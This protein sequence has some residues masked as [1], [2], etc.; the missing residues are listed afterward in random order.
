MTEQIERPATKKKKLPD[1]VNGNRTNKKTNS[2]SLLSRINVYI[3][4]FDMTLGLA[5]QNEKTNL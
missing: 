4:N 5:L 3:V 1:K 2:R